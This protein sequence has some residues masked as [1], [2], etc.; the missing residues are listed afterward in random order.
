[1]SKILLPFRFIRNHPN[2]VFV[3]S[4]VVYIAVIDGN[5]IWQRHF[6]WQRTAKLK[7]EVKAYSERYSKD[8]TA[9]EELKN[10]PRV[11]EKIARERYYMTRKGEDLFVI[12]DGNTPPTQGVMQGTP[13]V[14][15]KKND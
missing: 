15:I 6:V 8:S 11:V 1:M 5:S 9:L 12:Q 13:I 4:F 7:E 14:S 3:I 2:W 10:N